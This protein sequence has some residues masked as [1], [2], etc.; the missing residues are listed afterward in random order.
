MIAGQALVTEDTG[1]FKNR[2]EETR[3]PAHVHLVG[4][5]TGGSADRIAVR[6]FDVEELHILVILKL[7]DHQCQHLGHHVIHTL[8]PAPAIWVVGA[9]G[10]FPNAKK[11][12]DRL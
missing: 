1:A 4:N 5:Q 10:N 9:G 2:E 11:L 7:V 8:H 3:K 12:V 6:K